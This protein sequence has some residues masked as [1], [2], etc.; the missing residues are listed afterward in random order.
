[1]IATKGFQVELHPGHKTVE[2]LASIEKDYIEYVLEM[3]KYNQSKTAIALGISRGCLRMKMKQYF[4]DKY[5]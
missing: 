3:C 2:G 1:M 4:G 5:L